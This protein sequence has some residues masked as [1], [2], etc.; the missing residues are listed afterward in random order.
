MILNL[1]HLNKFVKYTKFKMD[2][3]EKVVQLL[4]PLDQMGSLDL[5][6][7]YGHLYIFPPTI[8]L[9][10]V[11]VERK[12]LLLHNKTL[13]QEF[14][15]APHMF[16]QVTQPLMAQ[17]RQQL[18]DIL[19]Y[20]DD[21]FLHVPSI[22]QLHINLAITRK[23][24]A[25]CGLTVNEE[26]SCLAPSQQMEFL[27]FLFDS[28]KFTITVTPA[29]SKALHNLVKSMLAKP[30][31]RVTIRALARVI[32]KIVSIFPASD[33]ALLHYRTLERFKTRQVCKFK[34]W[35]KMVELSHDCLSE[36]KWWD[37]HLSNTVLSKSLHVLTHNEEIFS[38]ASGY[39][40][41]STWRGIEVQGLFTEKQQLLSINTKELLAIYYALGTHASKFEGKV[42]L[43]RCDNMT[44]ISCIRK[45]GSSN[46]VRNRIT[47]KIFSLTYAHK[48]KI[49]ISC[50]KSKENISDSV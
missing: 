8:L 9:L 44:A 35:S 10:S 20:I 7:A 42:V 32:G 28:V 1:K 47:E 19:I 48:F 46:L 14:S 4:C 37:L 26:K 21:T 29:K 33:E 36:L 16:V 23:L 41:G 43:I 6:Q 22:N 45:K 40:Y 17:L 39:G 2:H 31:K 50:I 18:I 24:F 49:Q 3:I 34:N 27:G 15:D 38:D 25:D 5:V 13:P 11:H 30:C 12:I